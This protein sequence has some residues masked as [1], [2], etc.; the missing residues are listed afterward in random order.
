MRLSAWLPVLVLVLLSACAKVNYLPR[1]PSARYAPAS[2]CEVLWTAPVKPFEEIGLVTAES[3]DYGE[4]KLLEKLRAKAMKVGA[5]A[6]VMMGGPTVRN[7][8]TVGTG[9]GFASG[10]VGTF[11]GVGIPIEVRRLQGVAIR[12]Q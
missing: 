9:S 4:V 11:T 12:Y 5:D 8:V 3:D 6:I 1:D 7:G 2:R 10:G